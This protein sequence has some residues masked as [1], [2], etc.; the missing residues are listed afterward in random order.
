MFAVCE[1]GRALSEVLGRFNLFRGDERIRWFPPRLNRRFDCIPISRSRSELEHH[2]STNLLIGDCEPYVEV[3]PGSLNGET[4]DLNYVLAMRV[5]PVLRN[6]VEETM[7]LPSGIY[8]RE[9]IREE[10]CPCSRN[11]IPC[12]F[13]FVTEKAK[14][15]LATWPVGG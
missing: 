12:R 6:G 9:N 7:D 4:Q 3:L 14:V 11:A 8:W 2:R 1:V 15:A 10:L 13:K 5:A